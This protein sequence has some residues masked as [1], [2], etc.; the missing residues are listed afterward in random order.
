MRWICRAVGLVVEEANVAEDRFPIVKS[1]FSQF[2]HAA[3]KIVSELPI[4]ARGEYI[5]RWHA[6]ILRQNFVTSSGDEYTFASKFIVVAPKKVLRIPPLLAIGIAPRNL[7]HLPK[8]WN[9]VG[10][11]APSCFVNVASECLQP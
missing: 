8:L 4:E 2:L 9:T 10:Q 6:E 1:Q 5:D 3:S 7:L 11:S